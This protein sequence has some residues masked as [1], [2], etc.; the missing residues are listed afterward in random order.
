MT[1][2]G[3][4]V[5]WSYGTLEQLASRR[6]FDLIV[7]GGAVEEYKPESGRWPQAF[8]RAVNKHYQL[9]RRFDCPPCIGAA[10]VP[11][12]QPGE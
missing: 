5:D 4:S 12:P 7:L 11:K 10:Y 6:Y 3:S 8:I 2:L 9:A 1:Q